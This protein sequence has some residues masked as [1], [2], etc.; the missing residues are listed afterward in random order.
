MCC[1][2]KKGSPLPVYTTWEG[3]THCGYTESKQGGPPNEGRHRGITL[4]SEKT[5]SSISSILG[6]LTP[7]DV[8]LT[9][10]TGEKRFPIGYITVQVTYSKQHESLPLL[11]VPVDGPTFLRWN[12]LKNIKINWSYLKLVSP[13]FLTLDQVLGQHS[14]IFTWGWQTKDVM[15]KIRVNPE[16]QPHIFS[17][18]PIYPSLIERKRCIRAPTCSGHAKY[19]SC[20]AIRMGSPHCTGC[21]I[22]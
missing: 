13:P 3:D 11:V 14:K 22:R 21:E 7:S 19:H 15:A 6:P 12:W 20:E 9:T 8:I 17:A 10:Y 18:R 1:S 5:Y 4:I 2:C 16:A